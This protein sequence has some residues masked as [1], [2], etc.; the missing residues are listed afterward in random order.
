MRVV[1]RLS[2]VTLLAAGVA[3]QGP[4]V[5]ENVY[6]GDLHLHTR[7]SNDAA[8]FG[9]TRTPDDAYRY[10]KGEAVPHVGRRRDPASDAARLPGRDR[11]RREH[12][13][14]AGGAQSRLRTSGRRSWADT[15]R[16]GGPPLRAG[17]VHHVRRLRVD[18]G[19]A[20]GATCTATSSSRAPTTCPSRSRG[21]IRTTRRTSGTFWTPSAPAASRRW[22][23]PTTRTSATARCSRSST[24]RGA[25]MTRRLRGAAPAQRAGGGDNAGQGHVGDAPGLCRRTTSSPTSSCSPSSSP[26]TGPS[27]GTGP[28]A[29]VVRVDGLVPGSYAREAL[30]N[31]VRMQAEQGF[32]PVP[33]RLRRRDRLPFRH[34]G[35]GRGQHDEHVRRRGRRDARRPAR[36]Q[37]LE[38]GC[39]SS[40]GAPAGLTAAWANA[41]H[42][43]RALLRLPSP[44]DLRHH[45]HPHHGAFLR[46]LELRRRRAGRRRL[47]RAGIRWGASRW[48][49]CCAGPRAGRRRSS[50]GPRR[51]R[52]R[53]TSTASRSSRAGARRARRTSASTTWRCPTA[54]SVGPTGKAPPVGNTVD[55]M[56]R[57]LHQRH[58]RSVARGGLAGPR[59]RPGRARRLLRAG[60]RESPPRAGRP[61]T[62]RRRAFPRAAT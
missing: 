19:D 2:L 3:A 39:R 1:T 61:T 57:D 6:F 14:R 56:P 16:G 25:P 48:A 34:I 13:P 27:A 5:S 23:S 17:R 33:V 22:R 55:V 31:G 45:R 26:R 28:R 62:P 58:R 8:I 37:H 50:S 35:G 41:E 44:G 59:L 49:G 29:G 4:A 53:P 46:R 38:R 11:P 10:A 20:R 15:R 7:Y 32:N 43:R 36:H 51:T 24:S 52:W 54:G 9:T 12:R 18:G 30:V 40:R 47:G 60:D 21:S 42:P